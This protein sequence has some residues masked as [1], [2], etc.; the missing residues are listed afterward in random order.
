MPVASIRAGTIRKPPPI[1]KK[2]DSVPVERPRPTRAGRFERIH[3]DVGRPDPCTRLQHQRRNAQHDQCEQRQQLLA[4]KHLA[5][6]RAAERA[7]I[8]AAA[9]TSAQ[10][11]TT[12]PLRAWLERL[13]AALVATAIALVP[14]RDMGVRHADH[15]DHQ[16]H[17]K[18]RSTAADQAQRKSHQPARCEAQHALCRGDDQKEEFACTP[19]P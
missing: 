12:V 9:K 5:E 2:P 15:I 1:P 18:D 7:Q 16:R 13:T 3:L 19:R 14:D 10:D 6:Q 4:V 17:R 11:H 8:P